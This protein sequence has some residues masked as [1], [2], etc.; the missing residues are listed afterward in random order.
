MNQLGIIESCMKM[1]KSGQCHTANGEHMFLWLCRR[2]PVHVTYRKGK[3]LRPIVCLKKGI[4]HYGTAT[5]IYIAS[6]LPRVKPEY[7][8]VFV[9]EFHNLLLWSIKREAAGR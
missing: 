3:N 2:T 1:P 9:R 4:W 6:H 7:T 8:R 5:H